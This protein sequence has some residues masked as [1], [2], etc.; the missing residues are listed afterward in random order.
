MSWF[1]G[2][3][4]IL[5]RMPTDRLGARRDVITALVER[6]RL[7]TPTTHADIE[8]A[9][10]AACTTASTTAPHYEMHASS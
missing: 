1:D 3:L 7:G 10:V 2:Y 6:R 9:L 4:S 5:E 8:S